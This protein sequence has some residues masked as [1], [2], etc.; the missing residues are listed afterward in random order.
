MVDDKIFY[1]G[2][3]NFYPSSLQQFG[4]IIDSSEAVK[5]LIESYW[6]PMWKYSAKL[7]K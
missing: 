3:H 7:K 5:S 4:I 1:L 2:S 6:N